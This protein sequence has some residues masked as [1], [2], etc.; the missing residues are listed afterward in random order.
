MP[1]T[2]RVPIETPMF[3]NHA[4]LTRT[5]VIFF[6]RLASL[7]EGE[8]GAGQPEP[9]V[10]VL[11]DTNTNAKA[12]PLVQEK[13]VVLDKA[14]MI[15][16]PDTGNDAQITVDVFLDGVSIFGDSKLV[17]PAGSAVDTVVE[18]PVFASNPMSAALGQRWD[19]QVVSGDGSCM[20]SVMIVTR[21]A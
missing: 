2:P 14:I 13:D 19:A 8:T 11:E 9:R 1:V 5:W 7:R 17:M 6:E 18:Q 21:S 4:N 10:V 16:G 12:I 3:D 20:A 15:I